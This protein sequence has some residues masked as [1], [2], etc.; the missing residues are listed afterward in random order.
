MAARHLRARGNGSA[1]RRGQIT[2]RRANGTLWSGRR[3]DGVH[4]VLEPGPDR[5]PE[6]GLFGDLPRDFVEEGDLQ[7]RQLPHAEIEEMEVGDQL[8]EGE[9]TRK[10]LQGIEVQIRGHATA[11]ARHCE[12][13]KPSHRAIPP[14]REWWAPQSPG[15]EPGEVTVRSTDSLCAGP[16]R[17]PP[18]V[19]DGR[20]SFPGRRGNPPGGVAPWGH[21]RRARCRDMTPSAPAAARAAPKLCRTW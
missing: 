3:P 18:A 11:G 8:L 16:G 4:D 17:P 15:P 6:R 20:P 2:P 1:S 9:E 7:D 12:G 5:I 19:P 21:R 13:A 10:E 14:F